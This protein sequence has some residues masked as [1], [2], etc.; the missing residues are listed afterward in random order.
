MNFQFVPDAE[1]LD[2]DTLNYSRRDFIKAMGLG[3]VSFAVPG[4]TN[5]PERSRDKA[6]EKKPNIIFCMSDDQGWGDTGYNG[7][8]FEKVYSFYIDNMASVI[9]YNRQ[10]TGCIGTYDTAGDNT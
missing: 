3:V 2:I 5:L 6:A 1:R 8:P 7:H 9:W 4:C 10:T